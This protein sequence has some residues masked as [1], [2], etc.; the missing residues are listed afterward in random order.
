M[1]VLLIGGGGTTALQ[2]GWFPCPI[3]NPQGLVRHGDTELILGLSPL[4]GHDDG[5]TNHRQKLPN[6]VA[7]NDDD[8]E[9]ASAE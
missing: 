3:Q 9:V 1:R 8:I 4:V 5:P 2:V 7:R 6:P